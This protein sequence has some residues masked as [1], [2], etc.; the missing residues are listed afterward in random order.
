LV[1]LA[2]LIKLHYAAFV[3]LPLVAATVG[4]SWR[5]RAFTA[6]LVGAAVPVLVCAGWFA[7]KGAL[8]E[9][10]D[11]YVLFNLDT[12]KLKEFQDVTMTQGLRRAAS[13]LPVL[14]PLLALAVIVVAGWR[15]IAAAAIS[16][17]GSA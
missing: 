15:A 3:L 8:S 16:P 6:L 12:W 1:G 10:V 9:L 7:A 14:L 11:G 4:R 5:P 17:A 2:S 13:R